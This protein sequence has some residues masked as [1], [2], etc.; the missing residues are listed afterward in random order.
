VR[1]RE[2]SEHIVGKTLECA[3]WNEGQSAFLMSG[4]C[5]L[6]FTIDNQ[7]VVWSLISASQFDDFRSVWASDPEPIRLTRQCDDGRLLVSDMDRAT[8][9]A[10]IIGKMARR[11]VTNEF[12]VY[13][14]FEKDP[15]HLFF[16]AQT[17]A[18]GDT[19]FLEWFEDED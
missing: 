4:G 19:P 11:I 1:A 16:A 3:C 6:H 2:T 9:G 7:E 13:L 18:N 12:G 8:I 14:H 17:N 5:G 15:R 10:G